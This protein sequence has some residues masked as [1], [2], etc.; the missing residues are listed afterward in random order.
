MY[1]LRRQC[2]L[3]GL[4]QP[5][6]AGAMARAYSCNVSTQPFSWPVSQLD[7][8]ITLVPSSIAGEQCGLRP[9]L[10][11]CAQVQCAELKAKSPAHASHKRFC[12]WQPVQE[13][14]WSFNRLVSSLGTYTPEIATLLMARRL[15]RTLLSQCGTSKRE[16][17]S[18]FA[19]VLQCTKLRQSTARLCFTSAASGS[20]LPGSLLPQAG[21]QQQL[22]GLLQ[23]YKQLSKAKLSA[24]VVSTAA[25]GFVAGAEFGSS[26]FLVCSD[27]AGR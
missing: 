15:S 10:H 18:S 5:V 1:L 17:T 9:V 14:S 26:S 13:L 16:L 3:Q 4:L 6:C 20:A 11:G 8:K 25:A 27:S 19:D 2:L 21:V 7:C 22:S 12:A 23:I 24:L